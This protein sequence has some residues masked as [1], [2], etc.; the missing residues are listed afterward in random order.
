MGKFGLV[1]T[2]GGVARVVP[3][4]DTPA[5]AQASL[6]L[7]ALIEDEIEAFDEAVRR[8]TGDPRGRRSPPALV[9]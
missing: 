3:M 5:D 2:D 4:A 7:W 8:R 6:T 9:T 1:V